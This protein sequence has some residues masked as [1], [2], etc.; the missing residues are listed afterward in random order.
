M[1][2]AAGGGGKVQELMVKS[3][4]FFEGAVATSAP[5]AGAGL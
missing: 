3:F 4:Q 1:M 2:S 5:I